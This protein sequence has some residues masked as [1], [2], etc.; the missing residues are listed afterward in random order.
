M[1]SYQLLFD[2]AVIVL[3]H[4]RLGNTKIAGFL[5]LL[6]YTFLSTLLS[7][8]NI[9]DVFAEYLQFTV[10]H[11]HF[12]LEFLDITLLITAELAICWRSY[13]VLQC[14]TV[15]LRQI[16]LLFQLVYPVKAVVTPTLSHLEFG[17]ELSLHFAPFNLRKHLHSILVLICF[18]R[19]TFLHLQKN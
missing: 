2:W 8:D 19:S 17:L 16:P 15:I 6:L 11:V 3:H 10:L 7:F 5:L 1:R 18:L 14:Q 12:A 9:L 4:L 13:E